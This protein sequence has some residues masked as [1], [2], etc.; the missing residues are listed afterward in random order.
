MT[1]QVLSVTQWKVLLV[2][3][4]VL[5]GALDLWAMSYWARFT[6]PET[7]GTLAVKFG[8][9]RGHQRTVLS[10]ADDSPLLRAGARVGDKILFDRFGDGPRVLG[11]DES[12]GVT[13]LTKDGSRHAF[14]RP[15]PD[16]Q[17]ALH[18]AASNITA[19]ATWASVAI[20]LAVAL[21]VGL[22][23]AESSAMRALALALLTFS[24]DTFAYF[25]P[26]GAVQDFF[27]KIRPIEF[28]VAYV[29]FVHFV[30]RYP[31]DAPHFRHRWVR[32]T[33]HV[34]A[35]VFTAMVALR[36]A[37]RFDVRWAPLDKVDLGV[38]LQFMAICSVAIILVAL[39]I[40]WR[41]SAG[42]TQGRLAWIGVCMGSIYTSY[43][44]INLN[45]FL[46]T[47]ISDA[48]FAL[49]Q[50]TAIFLAF[51]GLGYAILRHRLFDFAFVVNR[52]VVYTIVSTLLLLIFAVT[53][54][55]V[56]KLL[57]FEGRQKNL[58]VDAVVALCIILS[59]HRIQH[60]VGHKVDLTLFRQWHEAAK[61]LRHFIE[62]AA[63][64]SDAGA[65]RTKFITAIE[66]FCG[67]TGCTIYE[68]DADRG[69]RLQQSTLASSPAAI[70]A[71]DDV[72]IE[73][74][75][76]RAPVYV[77]DV[78]SGLPGELA[79]SMTSR[80]YVRG[81]VLLGPKANGQN[82]RP[83][84][85]ALL[86]TSVQRLGLDL[87]GLRVQELEREAAEFQHKSDALEQRSLAQER[88][89]T[90]LRQLVAHAI[91]GAA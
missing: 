16:P 11:T 68:L 54:W 57:H 78:R 8:P 80:G 55:G 34:Y 53:E 4:V 24:P 10:L 88:E 64:I 20:S 71:N 18:P 33:F 29:C 83:D 65:L 9:S 6:S 15:I 73:L 48:T 81:L 51:C 19:V 69:F 39:W 75:T 41:R 58:I 17:V 66:A 62:K 91:H 23:N 84:E 42:T 52:A 21:L 87:E 13:I 25:L 45:P 30:L 49:Y 56:D 72:V 59:F 31:E 36:T 40:S 5:F 76:S 63:H 77:A 50:N 14:V 90:A 46:S 61:Q 79:L 38:G 22:R 7:A 3:L 85:L 2:S 47:P 1:R 67:T 43:L 82:Y 32:R 28:F 37:D 70:D 12:I 44:L 74:R 26:G 27:F 86:T 35:A 89:A 60:W